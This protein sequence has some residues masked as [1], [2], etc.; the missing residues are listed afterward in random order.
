MIM[1]SSAKPKSLHFTIASDKSRLVNTPPSIKTWL[2][3]WVGGKIAGMEEE[4]YTAVTSLS[5]GM[6]S[7]KITTSPVFMSTA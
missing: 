6:F 5:F 7:S 1:S 2:S 3:R 4:A